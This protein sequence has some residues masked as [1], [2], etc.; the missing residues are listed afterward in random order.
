MSFFDQTDSLFDVFDT[1]NEV[2]DLTKIKPP[3]PVEPIK[4]I[5]RTID[6]D[7]DSDNEETEDSS[8]I[9]K[10]PK[11]DIKSGITTVQNPILADDFE[12]NVQKDVKFNIDE[13]ELKE[14]AKNNE[15]SGGVENINITDNTQLVSLQH[16]VNINNKLIIFKIKSLEI[17]N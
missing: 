2:N 1:E 7:E 4:P 10:K 15:N 12:Q 5:K 6:E 3:V 13:Y 11:I 8:K 17:S 9:T 16:Q 14:K